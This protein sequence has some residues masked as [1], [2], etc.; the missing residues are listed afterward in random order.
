MLVV[1]VGGS[2]F[3]WKRRVE[4]APTLAVSRRCRFK[5]HRLRLT[6]AFGD[7][8]QANVA[9]EGPSGAIFV[10]YVEESWV[11]VSPSSGM[12]PQNIEVLVYADRAPGPG[13]HNVTVRLLPIEGESNAGTLDLT[14][15]LKPPRSLPVRSN[16]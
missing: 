10:T 1:L 5:P 7:R 13:K 16:F 9:T 4:T 2:Y 8:L 6:G 3:F 15:K 12:F 11:V 14:V